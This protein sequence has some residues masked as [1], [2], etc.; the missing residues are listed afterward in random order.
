MTWQPLLDKTGRDGG[1]NGGEIQNVAMLV[2]RGRAYPCRSD[3]CSHL[4]WVSWFC[5]GIAP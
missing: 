3:G 5:V 4:F 1:T 2:G